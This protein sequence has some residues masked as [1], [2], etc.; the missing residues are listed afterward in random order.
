[1]N[2]KQ[3]GITCVIPLFNKAAYIC[4][5]VESVLAQTRPADRIIIIDDGS[6]DGGDLAVEQH[7]TGRITL[8]RQSNSGPGAARNHG[9]RLATTS[10]V[11]FLDAD[12]LWLPHHVADL[13]M[14]A[15]AHPGLPLYSTGLGDTGLGDMST[16][17][18]YASHTDDLPRCI[19]DYAAAWLDGLIVSTCAVMVDRQIALDVGGFA[20]THPRGEDLA[21]WLKLSEGRAIAVTNRIGALYRRDASDLTRV[22]VQGP[23]AAMQWIAQR[24]EALPQLAPQRAQVLSDYRARL[25]LLHGA[26]WI[27]FGGRME[28]NTFLKLADVTTRDYRKLAQLR[29]LTGPLWPLRGLIIGLRRIFGEG[30]S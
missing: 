4:A 14:L 25:A 30:P 9:L 22:P 13:E 12:D 29:L 27:R 2:V 3:L 24:L 18:A 8:V 23:D 1:V 10:H 5:A 17:R 11:A 16:A 21:L 6:T 19:E 15:T 7:Y 20:T 28:A 26:E